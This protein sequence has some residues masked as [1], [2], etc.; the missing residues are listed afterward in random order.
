METIGGE[1]VI[2]ALDDMSMKRY[3]AVNVVFDY[4]KVVGLVNAMCWVDGGVMIGTEEGTIAYYESKKSKWKAKS[5]HPTFKI[6][7][8]I[9]NNKD[10][11]LVAR[12]N[13]NI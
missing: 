8:W 3:K 7:N 2:V 1:E 11:I 9:N 13:G 10:N 5:T 4:S 6:L 12:K